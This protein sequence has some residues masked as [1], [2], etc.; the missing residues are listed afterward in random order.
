MKNNIKIILISILLIL[1]SAGKSIAGGGEIVGKVIDKTTGEPLPF[2]NIII[3]GTSYGA[4]AD[5]KGNYRISQVPSGTY[6]VVAKFLGYNE[7]KYKN[8]Q[9]LVNR[10]TRINFELPP[11]T[12]KVSQEVVVQAKRPAV[13]LEVAS[14]AKVITSKELSNLSLITN[15]KD[16]VAMQSGVVKT[17]D[18]IHIRGGR[19][20]EVLYLID[21]VPARNP[22]T[23]INSVEVD[24][25][26]IEQVE[27]ITGG[28]DAEYG[29][30]NSGVINIITKS[31]R[32]NFTS[33]L[34]YKTDNF[35]PSKLGTN[36]D[37]AYW[38]L[39]G[40]I[41]FFDWLGFSG[42]SGFTLSAKTN[43]N[44]TYYFIGGGFGKTDILGME[45]NNRQNSD[46]SINAQINVEP[47]SSFRIKVQ[48]QFD[49][50]ANKSFNLV[51]K[52]LPENLPINFYSTNRI[53]VLI[54]HT[55]SKNAYYN[56][57]FGYT[58]S[59]TKNSLLNLKSPLQAFSY[60]V[61]YFDHNGNPIDNE[62]AKYLLEHNPSSIDFS[63]TIV[64]Y[65]RPTIPKDTDYDGFIDEGTFADFHLNNYKTYFADFDF[66][67][68]TGAHK[69]KT[70]FSFTLNK[71]D[72]LD[73][74]DYGQYFP[75]RDTIPGAWPQYG[76][77]RWYFNDKTYNGSFYVQDRINYAG[78]FLNLGV[79]GDFYGHGDVINDPYFIE[80]FN[81]ATGENIRSFDKIKTVI[82][83]RLGL[84]IPANK[85]TKLFFNYGYFIQ[86][87]GFEE[88]YRDPFLTSVVGNPNLNPRKSINYEVGMETEFI[89]N[90]VLNIK[91]YGRDYAGDIGYRETNTNPVR[92]IYDNIGFGSSRGFEIEFRK[93]YSNY[94]SFTTNYTY[95]LARGFDLTALRDYQT[96]STV[97]PSVREQRVGWDINHNL[98][99]MFNFEVLENNKLNL[100]FLDLTDFGF[101]F[102]MTAN[103]GRPYTP[104]IP[105]AIYIE[106]N[107]A[108]AQGEF[109]LDATL[110]KGF[111]YGSSRFV[112]FAEIKNLLDYR[113][114]NLGSAFNRRTGRI[115]NLG[116]LSGD[117]N[118]YL[119]FH[120]VE[121]M[122]AN[123][124]YSPSRIIRLGMKLYIR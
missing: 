54:N 8:V 117:T 73:I 91:L 44:D 31:G 6:T 75:Y 48:G 4:A 112:L 93:I 34:I 11:K 64:Q 71:I 83:P 57:N 121:F 30:A 60:S 45:F 1:I 55:L 10:I 23:G 58:E 105:R 78:M 96:G 9:V 41:S 97:P 5:E 74:W 114:I 25:N 79:R 120:E 88:L 32:S 33:D 107:S 16:L 35:M 40:P 26:Q 89:K 37:Y 82:S 111:R 86:Q 119:T 85:D 63:R 53:T 66:T 14:T 124:A 65:Q 51:W 84:S 2:A 81:K 118:R 94:F 76:G 99:L 68:F 49:K 67:Y 36:F 100:G 80:Q 46:Y 109:Y 42:G 43:L 108:N 103:L 123:M 17:G 59:R 69:M 47:V 39:S 113:N 62:T 24:V 77:S 102:L 7:V 38:G 122:R 20:D 104:I 50:G 19:S 70:G 115:V 90:Y 106:P 15:V 110:Y 56:F 29:N 52:N 87:P 92:L 22:V 72:H 98:K 116:D 28:F 95:L 3:W 27:I 13:D 101:Y 61:K 18:K 21:G 12:L